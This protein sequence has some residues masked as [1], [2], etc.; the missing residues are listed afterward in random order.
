KKIALIEF[1]KKIYISYLVIEQFDIKT[2]LTSTTITSILI[3]KICTY[4][5]IDYMYRILI[6]IFT[7]TEAKLYKTFIFDSN[8]SKVIEK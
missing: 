3:N 8:A 2:D 7:Q 1:Y 6:L 5:L 4:R